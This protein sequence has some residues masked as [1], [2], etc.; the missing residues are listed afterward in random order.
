MKLFKSQFTSLAIL[1]LVCA[2]GQ[3]DNQAEKAQRDL[4][5]ENAQVSLEAQAE[6]DALLTFALGESASSEVKEQVKSMESTGVKPA[7][8]TSLDAARAYRMSLLKP[9]IELHKALSEKIK[10]TVEEAKAKN[11]SP[12]EMRASLKAVFDSFKTQLD[13]EHARIN[14]AM[15]TLKD[16]FKD[17]V[18]LERA[19]FE[20]CLIRRAPQTGPKPMIHAPRPGSVPPPQVGAPKELETQPIGRIALVDK[21]NSTECIEAAKALDVFVKAATAK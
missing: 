17:L 14:A 6:A 15:Q 18:P 20:A 13:A 5:S 8:I 3:Q 21:A 10:A 2:C 7:F 4:N 19:V 1:A 11:A 9:N 12:E 16:T